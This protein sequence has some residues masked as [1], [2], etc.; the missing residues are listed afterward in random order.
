MNSTQYPSTSTILTNGHSMAIITTTAPLV[1]W[2]TT[3]TTNS[4]TTQNNMIVNSSRPTPSPTLSDDLSNSSSPTSSP[5]SDLD[6]NP[7]AIRNFRSI[8]NQFKDGIP[9]LQF[10]EEY[11]RKFG[12]IF[13]SNIWGFSSA[14][15]LF[16][17][18]STVFA[19]EIPKNTR[20][21]DPILHDARY[22]SF[23]RPKP[24][25]SKPGMNFN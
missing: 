8:L 19:I 20:N 15:E 21:S 24:D 5:T 22:K 11:E 1:K 7:V 25:H 10:I 4:I 18:L 23:E 16:Y 2:S 9:S 6:I 3:S 12:V 14:M 13:Q 17:S